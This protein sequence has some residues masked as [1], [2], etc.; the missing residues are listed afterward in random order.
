MTKS[1]MT[2]L[3]GA[4]LSMAAHAGDMFYV[5]ANAGSTSSDMSS[6]V[7]YRADPNGEVADCQVKGKAGKLLAG[8]HVTP[9]FALEASYWKFGTEHAEDSVGEINA[10]VA[11]FG[12]GGALHFD[13]TDNWALLARF[14]FAR[15]KTKTT[16]LDVGDT[17][18]VKAASDSHAK[19]YAGIGISY[20]VT[21][22][23]RLHG[24]FDY[25]KVRSAI[26]REHG[27]RLLSAGASLN[28]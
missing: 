15:V 17:E 20:A 12:L 3:A 2:A 6:C 7:S 19:Y 18:W 10:K 11:A 14:G 1:L 16:T 9:N 28:F 21:P 23:F 24:D 5:Q 27:L 13:I 4:L 8:Y 26:Y 25:T 22:M